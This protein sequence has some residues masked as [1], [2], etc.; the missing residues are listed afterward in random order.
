[1]A[2]SCINCQKLF[3]YLFDTLL[4]LYSIFFITIRQ[5]QKKTHFEIQI[6]L[7]KYLL[8]CVTLNFD[9]FL[10]FQYFLS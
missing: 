5:E 3:L 6:Y 10:K 9:L 1:M 4:E 8:H 7:L 2:I